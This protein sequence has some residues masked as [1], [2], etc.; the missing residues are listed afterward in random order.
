MLS[1][2]VK[3]LNELK[4]NKASTKAI[5]FDITAS[6]KEFIPDIKNIIQTTVPEFKDIVEEYTNYRIKRKGEI[7]KKFLAEGFNRDEALLLM[8][9]AEVALKEKMN[10]MNSK[11]K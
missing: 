8:I 9:N 1:M 4:E 11:K 6:L 10:N 5:L 2:L 7:F 3:I